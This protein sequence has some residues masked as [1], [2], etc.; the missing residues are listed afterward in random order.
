MVRFL[1]EHKAEKPEEMKRFC[2]LGYQYSEKESTEDRYV[3]LKDQ[4]GGK[5]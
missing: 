2:P 1:A 3:F 5:K 4:G